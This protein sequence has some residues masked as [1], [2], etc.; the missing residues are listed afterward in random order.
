MIITKGMRLRCEDANGTVT[1]IN[2]GSIYEGCKYIV[3]WDDYGIE[4]QYRSKEQCEFDRLQ[5]EK[6]LALGNIDTP[7]EEGA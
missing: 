5:Y 6:W 1:S 2:S 4:E 3:I 7:P